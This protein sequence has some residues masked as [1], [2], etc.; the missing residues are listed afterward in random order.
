MVCVYMHMEGEKLSMR[1]FGTVICCITWLW[2][3]KANSVV[4]QIISLSH[5]VYQEC[6]AKTVFI[7]KNGVTLHCDLL[8]LS[9]DISFKA[10]IVYH[11]I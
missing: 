6:P 5:F 10:P 8:F 11:V 4:G 3:I 9:F 7:A 2:I 1:D